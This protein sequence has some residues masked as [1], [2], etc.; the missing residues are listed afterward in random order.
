MKEKR[1]THVI[2]DFN[3]TILDDV[4]ASIK[5]ADQLLSAYGLPTLAS[6]EAYRESFGFPIIDYYR[7]LGF[8]FDK[9]P[10]EV[11]APEWVG[12]YL[13]NA[14]NAGV[15]EGLCEVLA[16]VQ[17][18]KIPQWILSATE[19]NML[20]RQVSDLGILSYFEGLLG[21]DNI[22]AHS[23]EQIALEWRRSNP[24]ACVLMIGDTDHDAAVAAAMGADCVLLTTGHQSRARLEACKCLFVADT[25][26][27][28]LALL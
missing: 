14:R 15:Y 16:E 2:W 1:Y 5:S 6:P 8:D 22:H 28:I 18:R 3:G 20:T 25:A 27:E 9:I 21:M 23:K 24:D 12:Y 7:R 11:L 26:K 13:E 19:H 4:E 17:T 10:Y